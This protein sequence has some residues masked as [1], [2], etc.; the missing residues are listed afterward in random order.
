MT[1]DSRDMGLNLGGLF[2]ENAIE[3]LKAS[4]VKPPLLFFLTLCIGNLCHLR[5]FSKEHTL[6]ASEKHYF[7]LGQSSK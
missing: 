5:S 6:Y 3:G 1:L 7:P 4:V 2:L